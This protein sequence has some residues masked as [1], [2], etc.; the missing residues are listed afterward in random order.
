[1]T[2]QQIGIDDCIRAGQIEKKP[3]SIMPDMDDLDPWQQLIML[4][5]APIFQ[6]H[7]KNCEFVPLANRV[8]TIKANDEISLQ[9]ICEHCKYI[10]KAVLSGLVNDP[11]VKILLIKAGKV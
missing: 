7:L 4:L 2:N 6:E 8:I 11:Y 5:T 3:M 10:I 1:M 9:W